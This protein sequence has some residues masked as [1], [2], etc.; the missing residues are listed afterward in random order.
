MIKKS[1]V[2]AG[3]IQFASAIREAKPELEKLGLSVLIR[4]S[5]PLSAGEVL[6]CTAPRI[7]SKSVIGSFNDMVWYLWR[8]GGSIWRE[9]FMMAN[10]EISAFRYDPYLGKLF[11]EEYDHQGMKE[12]RKRPIERAREA[13]SWG[14]VLGTLGRQ[15]NPRNLDS[16]ALFEQ[17]VDAWIQ[18]ACPR[19]SIDWGEA[20]EKP[21][22]T[23]FE[24]EI[25]VVDLPGW[26]E[27]DKSVVANSG[28][29]NGLGCGHSN[30]LCSGCG[31]EAGKDV[32]GVGDSFAGDYPMDYY[33]QDGGEWNSSYLKKATRPIRRN[34]VSSTSD[35]AAL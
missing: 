29:C 23:P 13:K 28:C 8:M 19:L 16:I 17:S 35:G 12:T 9:A 7:P 33:A 22:L 14:I 27:K 3:T 31:N 24:A 18:I 11:L 4:Q 6:G 34:V 26:W 30:G 21:L 15:G 32:K 25:A 10:P 20:F 5:K 2:L 1:I